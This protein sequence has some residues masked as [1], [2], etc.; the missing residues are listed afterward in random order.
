MGPTTFRSRRSRWAA[1]M[2]ALAGTTVVAACAVATVRPDSVS[3]APNPY[4]GSEATHTI[5]IDS[6]G[7]YRVHID[8]TMELARDYDFAFGGAIHDGFRLPDTESVL[9]PYLRAQY[10]D[11]AIAMDGQA[12]EVDVDHLIHSVS[13]SAEDTFTAGEHEGTIDYRV[14]GAAVGAAQAKTNAGGVAVYFRPLV[15]GDVIVQTD[16]A[17]SAVECEDW[18]PVGEPC[19]HKSGEEWLIKKD[20][21]QDAEAVHVILDID[22]ADL[23]KPRIDVTK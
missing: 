15:P 22:E 6:D 9:P 11:P 10:S 1:G 7:S 13:I 14:T 8:Q 3:A 21:L 23:G 12:A 18:P 16:E 2:A 20:E 4:V 19:G 5:T 17:I